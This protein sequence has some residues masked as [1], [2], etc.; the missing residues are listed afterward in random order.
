MNAIK[1]AIIVG[2]FQLLTVPVYALPSENLT[3]G[4]MMNGRAWVG[5]MNGPE[6]RAYLVGYL[7]GFD[8]LSFF[9]DY[10]ASSMDKKT[11]DQI[12]SATKSAS[13]MAGGKQRNLE[14]IV[15]ELDAFFS[16]G[17]NAK[18]PIGFGFMYVNKKM[19]GAS[20]GELDHLVSALRRSFS[21]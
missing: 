20:Q 11:Y 3:T 7:N 1:T 5:L 13:D 4:G 16:E 2:L 10:S 18:I 21:E 19:Q 6:K 12:M 9:I 15:R 14:D 17:A 8:G